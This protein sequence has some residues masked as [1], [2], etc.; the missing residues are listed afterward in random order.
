MKKATIILAI[1]TA[2]CALTSCGKEEVSYPQFAASKAD[3]TSAV[4]ISAESDKKTD[5]SSINNTNA[6]YEDIA[7]DLIER[8][9]EMRPQ[10]MYRFMWYSD[11]DDT[12]TFRL[13]NPYDSSE[14]QEVVFARIS[15]KGF[16]FNSIEDI[17]NYRRTVLSKDYAEKIG[18]EKCT[19]ISDEYSSGDYIDE[20]GIEPLDS[21]Y[22]TRYIMYKG[23]MYTNTTPMQLGYIGHMPA[24]ESVIITDVTDTTFRAYYSNIYGQDGYVSSLGCDIVDFIIDPACG[25]WRINNF[26]SDAY[27]VYTNKAAELSITPQIKDTAELTADAYREAAQTELER[28]A[29]FRKENAESNES[30][31]S[32]AAPAAKAFTSGVSNGNVYVSD[33]AGIKITIPEDA[34]FLDEANLN[35]H[36]TMPTRFMSAEEKSFYMTGIIDAACCYGDEIK[37]VD[38]W[39]YNTKLR[40]PETPDISAEEFMQRDELNFS[41][42]V[43][44][45]D[46]TTPE[47]VSICG[48]EYIRA[49]YTAFSQAHISYARRIDDNYIM[50]I[51]TSGFSA[52]DIESR[53]EALR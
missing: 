40:Y 35:T 17:N 47:R 30:T 11:P 29:E 26:T 8:F 20:T 53:I 27:D 5:I 44:V 31:S 9:Y 6:S 41:S 22:Y 12:V 7:N 50:I 52:D 18:T 23:N 15:G 14:V 37:R 2:I 42:D 43:D 48:N 10:F 13:S 21:L 28:I 49:S 36:Y 24:N 3:G 4:A 25:E 39:F 51:R 38:V 46:I 16:E 33:Y 19:D 32:N 1:T 34:S 45:T